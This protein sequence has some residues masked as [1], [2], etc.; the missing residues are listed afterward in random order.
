MATYKVWNPES[1]AL[2]TLGSSGEAEQMQ[3]HGH[4]VMDTSIGA[5]VSVS[6]NLSA[7]TASGHKKDVDANKHG[8]T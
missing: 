2:V 5:G 6:L 4:T 8:G 7:S 3:Y 1:K